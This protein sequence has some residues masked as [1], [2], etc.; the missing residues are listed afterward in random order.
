MSGAPAASPR[1]AAQA[2]TRPGTACGARTP[3]APAAE[4]VDTA[5]LSYQLVAA[6]Q[7]KAGVEYAPGCDFKL[8]TDLIPTVLQA[9]VDAVRAEAGGP[10]RNWLASKLAEVAAAGALSEYVV[11]DWTQVSQLKPFV[12]DLAAITSQREPPADGDGFNK[13]GCFDAFTAQHSGAVKLFVQD[14][15][16]AYW[17]V[18]DA[19]SWPYNV[20][21]HFK[22]PS[23]HED[24]RMTFDGRQQRTAGVDEPAFQMAISN[25]R[26]GQVHGA[27]VIVYTMNATTGDR[28]PWWSGWCPLDSQTGNLSKLFRVGSWGVQ[29]R[30]RAPATGGGSPRVGELSGGAAGFAGGML[31]NSSTQGGRYT[32]QNINGELCMD[33]TSKRDDEPRWISLTNFEIVKILQEMSY[34]TGLEAG[35]AG[36]TVILCRM[37]LDANGSDSLYIAH[38]STERCPAFGNYQWLE[39]EVLCQPSTI[40]S[41]ADLYGCFNKAHISLKIG[42]LKPEHLME[43][44]KSLPRQPPLRIISNWFRQPD[45]VIV[46]ANCCLLEGQFLSHAQAQWHFVAAHFTNLLCPIAPEQFPRYFLLPSKHLR[47]QVFLHI[48]DQLMPRFFMNNLQPARAVLAYSIMGMQVHKLWGGQA[49]V[50]KCPVALLY[51]PGPNTGKTEAMRLP[52]AMLGFSNAALLA[53]D[54]SKPAMMEW[55]CQNKAGAVVFMDDCKIRDGGKHF[56]LGEVVHAVYDRD[57]RSVNGKNRTPSSALCISVTPAPSPPNTTWGRHQSLLDASPT[58]HPSLRTTSPVASSPSPTAPLACARTTLSPAAWPGAPWHPS[59]IRFE[60]A[61]PRPPRAANSAALCAHSTHRTCTCGAG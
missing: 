42:A 46:G 27:A 58:P 6:V 47:Y 40:R 18:T 22:L 30:R 37:L 44:L 39:V 14:P 54:T 23:L 16:G 15:S 10:L 26:N 5:V 49:G 48:Y 29:P 56:T 45:G 34:Q 33:I 31:V 38:D 4:P 17:L 24:W 12:G 13:P 36:Y 11:H 7:T 57:M 51:S 20:Q 59:A 43:Y 19:R 35:N 41:S 9:C 61:S 25:A 8:V 21:H 28:M 1:A 53:G 52:H 50:P 32:F 3:V 2:A 55:V 60:L